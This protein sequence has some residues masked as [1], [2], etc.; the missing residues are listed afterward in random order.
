LLRESEQAATVEKLVGTGVSITISMAF[1]GV[2]IGIQLLTALVLS[3]G[4]AAVYFLQ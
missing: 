4:G 2:Y 3:S 1:Q